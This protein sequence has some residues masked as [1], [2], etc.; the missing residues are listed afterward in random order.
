MGLLL[1]NCRLTVGI[2]PADSW[3]TVYRQSADRLLGELFFSFTR[4]TGRHNEMTV[5]TYMYYPIKVA[6]G[7]AGFHCMCF[8]FGQKLLEVISHILGTL[9]V[10]FNFFSFYFTYMYTD[11][12]HTF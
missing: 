7:K 11:S 2:L 1:V 5:Y 12:T 10:K 6:V 4:K 8:C 9:Q 3:P